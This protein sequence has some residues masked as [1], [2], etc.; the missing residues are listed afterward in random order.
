MLQVEAGGRNLERVPAL[1]TALLT[2]SVI[3]G[4]LQPHQSC[5]SCKPGPKGLSMATRDQSSHHP[6]TPFSCLLITD[7]EG[8][9]FHRSVLVS[10]A[11][12]EVLQSNLSSHP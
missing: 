11:M 2:F 6:K 8:E 7:L 4:G 12:R 3:L 10:I 5:K 9:K 1:Q